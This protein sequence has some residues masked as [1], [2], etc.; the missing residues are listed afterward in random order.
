MK[1]SLEDD[2]TRVRERAVEAPEHMQQRSLKKI[3]S[4]QV[5]VALEPES[6]DWNGEVHFDFIPAQNPSEPSPFGAERSSDGD[7]P[8][9]VLSPDKLAP[10]GNSVESDTRKDALQATPSNEMHR[11]NPARSVTMKLCISASQVL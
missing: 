8:R 10:A 5:N 9:R 11:E 2:T 4:N 6:L 1:R 3:G 7:V